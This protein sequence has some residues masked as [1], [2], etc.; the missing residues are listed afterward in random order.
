MT[1]QPVPRDR[2]GMRPAARRLAAAAVAATMATLAV[3]ALSAAR[4]AAAGRAGRGPGIPA[5]G[6]LASARGGNTVRAW[7][8]NSEGELGDGSTTPSLLPVLVNA[9]LK[10]GTT[11]TS[12]RA[13]SIT[14]W[15]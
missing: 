12:V 10:V 4:A 15:R 1:Q 14:R 11:I 2:A 7:G 6:Q 13:G 5:A 9:A 3:P 8:D